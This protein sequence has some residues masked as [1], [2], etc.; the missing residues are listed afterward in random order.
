[1]LELGYR[2]EQPWNIFSWQQE[3]VQ[4]EMKEYQKNIGANSK[5]LSITKAGTS[6]A[7]K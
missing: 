5:E 4:K 3:H 7:T 6:L 2:N 1:M